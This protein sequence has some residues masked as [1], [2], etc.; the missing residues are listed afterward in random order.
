[1]PEDVAK[2]AKSYTGQYLKEVL[3]RPRKEAAE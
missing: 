1:M 2:S 3:R